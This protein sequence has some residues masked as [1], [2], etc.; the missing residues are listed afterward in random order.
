M[1]KK[2]IA[3]VS[4]SVGLPTDYPAFLESLKSRVQQAQTRAMLSV[5]RE[6]IQLYW[7]IGRLI[8]ER[9]EREGWGKGIVDRLAA[10]VQKAFPGLGGFSPVN[11]W[12]MRAFY[13]AYRP[14]PAIPSQPATELKA[15]KRS[16]AADLSQA[17]T[18]MAECVPPSPVAEI[19]W[20]H[21]V[22][23]VSKVKDHTQRLWYASKTLEHGWSRAVLTVQI[24]SDLFGRQG[25]AISNFAGT[26]PAPQSDLAQQSLKDPYL[27]DF[28][29]LQEDAVERDL[30]R[31]LVDHIQKFLLEL[32]AG[33]A[34]VGRQ[35]PLPVGDEDDYLDL[36]FY[37]LKL[38]CFI[39]ID[40][41][42]R[43][44]T[45]EDAG[46]MNYYL[47]AVDDL[48]KHPTDAPSVGLI[49]CKS[50]DRIK[51]EYA[52][53]DISKPIGVAEWQTK[54]VKSLPETLKGSL[55]TIE[56]LE[57]EFGPE[58]SL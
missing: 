38:R 10:D 22:I 11:V 24:E 9:Q 3:A 23:L 21:N 48:M 17:A 41:K 12:R 6:L 42:M 18:E 37:H 52:L 54:L 49:L 25:K 35:V 46:K 44:F 58:G 56:Q 51:A 1:A 5:N 33:F 53:R 32:G 47:S 28:L 45:P 14:A 8:V 36:L 43:K 15:R 26:L 13:V 29:T 39:V 19:P 30:E 7:D 55:P 16:K 50:R 4:A 40:L 31:G 34:F 2:K 20:F 27:F 57:A